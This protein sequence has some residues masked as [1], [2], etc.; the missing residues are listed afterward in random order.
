M[1][2]GQTPPDIILSHGGIVRGDTSTPEIHLVFTGHEFNEGGKLIRK[3]LKKHDSPA[4]FF[5]TGDFYRDPANKKLIRR[6]KR[7]GHYLGAHSDKHLLYATWEDRDSLLI[8]QA[9]FTTDLANNYSE[10]AK[11]G[12]SKTAAPYFMPPYEWYNKRISQW[13]EAYDLTLVNF[14]QGTRSNADYTW[15]ESGSRYV[16]SG[17]IYDSIL[18]YEQNSPHGLN[19]FILLLHLGTDPRRTDKFYYRLDVLLTDLEQRG[20]TFTLM[21]F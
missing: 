14:T 21:Q 12:I 16:D 13:T 3:V 20:Y 15:P 19:G 9:T 8:D 7:D 4:H 17:T 11:F 2:L 10:M 5:F 18:A 6:L 1:L